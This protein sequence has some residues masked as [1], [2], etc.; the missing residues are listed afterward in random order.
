MIQETLVVIMVALRFNEPTAPATI[1]CSIIY[2]LM[3]L[4]FLVSTFW[5]PAWFFPNKPT[6]YISWWRKIGLPVF[7][8]VPINVTYL[9]II[10]LVIFAIIESFFDFRS[11]DFKFMSRITLYK[12]LELIVIILAAAYVGVEMNIN[13]LVS[14]EV[15]RV[16]LAIFIVAMYVC[17]LVE[18]VFGVKET[19]FENEV[20]NER[21]Q[22]LVVTEYC[23]DYAHNFTN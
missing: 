7:A 9:L 4:F 17:W 13:L 14:T 16:F 15:I 8:I 23:A 21:V 20:A 18:I 19:Y 3:L 12:L 1:S 22:D 5:E 6:Q 2:L 11:G 10:F